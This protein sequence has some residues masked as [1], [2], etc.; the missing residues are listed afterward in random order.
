MKF[1]QRFFVLFFFLVIASSQVN[2]QSFKKDAG[3]PKNVILLIGDGMGLAQVHA[4]K[5]TSS[6]PLNILTSTH[7]GMMSTHSAN[8]EVT[9]SGAGGTAIATGFKTNNGMIGMTP[10]SVEVPSM[11]DIF[12]SKGS[13]TGVVVSCAVT[14]AT[15]AS[16]IA[17]DASRN[18]YED[19]ALDYLNSPVDVVIGGG[20]KHFNKRKDGRT[21]TKELELKGF[22]YYNELPSNSTKGASKLLI[23][24]DS[25][26]PVKMQ[27][28]RG[29]LLPNG[30]QLALETLGKNTKGFFLMVEGSQID[31][32]GHANDS[33]YL[34]AEMRDFDETVGVVLDFLKQ[35]P[36]TLV[37]VTADHETGGLT[38]PQGAIKG[39]YRFAYSSGDHT[40]IMVPVYAYGAGAGSFTGQYDNTDLIKKIMEVTGY[41]K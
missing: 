38:F 6:T 30:T 27:E 15:P 32:A 10:D 17:K 16:F 33:S 2:A 40:G 22:T 20:L 8:N 13:S 21:L 39:T 25:V 34:I 14:H 11:L 35:N 29:K 19:I 28:G 24:T 5:L 23:L 3:K 1:L 41:T 7:M 9:D 37:I 31:W 4:A 12:A 26:H 18:H 36:E